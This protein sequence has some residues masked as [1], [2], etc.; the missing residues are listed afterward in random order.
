[1]PRA[2]FRHPCFLRHDLWFLLFAQHSFHRRFNREHTTYCV[3]SSL[4]CTYM[5][6]ARVF[7]CKRTFCVFTEPKTTEVIFSPESNLS[8]TLPSGRRKQ[9]Q[10]TRAC[11]QGDAEA[12]AGTGAWMRGRVPGN[13]GARAREHAGRKRVGRKRANTGAQDGV[14]A[15]R[16]QRAMRARRGRTGGVQVRR[17]RA[18]RKKD[19]PS[20]PCHTPDPMR[21]R[22]WPN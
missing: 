2:L 3:S 10:K 16:T 12:G 18:R 15:R 21:A 7:A 9:A 8:Q 19:A 1:M 14:Q 4:K 17:G 13:A 5:V 11:A 20:L 6:L 22:L